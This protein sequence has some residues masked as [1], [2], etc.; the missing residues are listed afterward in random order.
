MK[1]PDTGRIEAVVERFGQQID[2]QLRSKAIIPAW[3]MA[4]RYVIDSNGISAEVPA[5]IMQDSGY[6]LFGEVHR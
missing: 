3:K 6:V 4:G 2:S 1:A 5:S